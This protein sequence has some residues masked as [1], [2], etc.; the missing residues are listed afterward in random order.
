[1]EADTPIRR[2]PDPGYLACGVVGLLLLGFALGVDFR[3]AAFGF[4]S[5]GATYY[6]LA[7]SLAH[8]FDFAFER[9][10]LE[11]VWHEFPTGPEGIFLKK[12][13]RVHLGL[14]GEFPF[15]W[16]TSPDTRDDRLYY[17]KS[18]AHPLFA[19][20]F[21]LLFGT[22]GFLVFHALLLTLCLVCGYAWLRAT[23]TSGIAVGYAFAFLFASA[24][25]VYLVWLT[26]EVFNLALVFLG[27]FLWTYKLVAPAEHRGRGPVQSGVAPAG[28]VC[29]DL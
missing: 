27:T 22:N 28:G 16:S 25:P 5:D 8:D 3:R 11:R 17:A 23:S 1:M 20:P 2:G 7:Y 14:A 9:K 18:F 4:Q 15:L 29:R 24:A 13:K 10:D 19:A 6:S 12:G 26:P 21:V